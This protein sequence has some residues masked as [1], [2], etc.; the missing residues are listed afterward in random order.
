MAGILVGRAASAEGTADTAG[1]GIGS[2]VGE[3]EGDVEGSPDMHDTAVDIAGIVEEDIAGM[4]FH[5]LPCIVVDIGAA[6]LQDMADTAGGT[7]EWESECSTPGAVGVW[8]EESGRRQKCLE[9]CTADCWSL[10]CCNHHLPG[11][12]PLT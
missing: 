4:G 7:E 5:D 11:S 1:G 9:C 3:G 12:A 8:E 2:A 6:L 10:Q